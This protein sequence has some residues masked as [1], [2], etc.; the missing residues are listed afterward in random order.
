V[1][2]FLLLLAL[3][4]ALAAPLPAR[5]QAPAAGTAITQTTR[6]PGGTYH[7]PSADR[8]RPAI[9]IRGDDVALVGEGAVDLPPG[10]DTAR[11]I[12]ASPSSVSRY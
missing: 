10:R 7:L 12:S 3:P 2:V 9:I 4:V 6:I 8:T 11:T 1:R 5:T